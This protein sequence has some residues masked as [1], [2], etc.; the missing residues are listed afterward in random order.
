MGNLYVRLKKDFVFVA[1]VID[2]FSRKIR[3]WAISKN[4]DHTLPLEALRKALSNNPAPVIH[5]SDQ[6][7]QYCAENYVEALKERGIQIS[8]SDKGNPYQNSITESFFKTLKYNEIYLN[9]YESFEE[10]R[11][12]IE[13]FIEIV[14]LES[15]S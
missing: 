1:V 12:N 2:F 3:G 7:V 6:G 13:R 10:A 8:M 11:G 9:E 4:L 14:Y 5:H 15:I